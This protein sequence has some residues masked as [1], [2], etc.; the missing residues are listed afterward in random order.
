MDKLKGYKTVAFNVIMA[1]L[2]IVAILNP[3]AQLPS[4]ETISQNLDVIFGAYATLT[5]TGNLILR[6]V[7]NS[8]IFKKKETT[9]A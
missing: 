8:P 7:T 6:A 3:D 5:A 1:I 4:G 9:N 2:P